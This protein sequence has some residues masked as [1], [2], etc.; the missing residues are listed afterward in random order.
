MIFWYA[1]R[2]TF[3]NLSQDIEFS[4]D[5]FIEWSK[6]N[7]L[8]E[9]ISLDHSLNADLVKPNLKNDD[10]W[11]FIVIDEYYHTGFYTTAEYVLKNMV[12]QDKFNFLTVVK[13]PNEKCETIQIKDFEF[14][15]YDLLD[16]AYE[17][18]ALTNCGG[19][20]ESFSSHELNQFGLL[21]DFEKAYHVQK[22][23]LENNPDEYHAD[24][25]VI[26]VWRHKTIGRKS[27]T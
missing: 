9:L 22:K 2:E 7:H 27:L 10:D 14:I 25:N 20:D 17:I 19:F 6:L 3:D 11:N 15:G 13:E 16:Y 23:L 8:K 1:A 21:S 5:K 18:S 12:R 24:C 26:A 4:W